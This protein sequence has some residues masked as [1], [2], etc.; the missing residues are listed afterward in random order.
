MPTDFPLW[1]LR[2]EDAARIIILEPLTK[3]TKLKFEHKRIPRVHLSPRSA[4]RQDDLQALNRATDVRK[5]EAH[6]EAYQKE[7]PVLGVL[8]GPMYRNGRFYQHEVVANPLLTDRPRGPWAGMY[9]R[10]QY[11]LDVAYYEAARALLRENFILGQRKEGPYLDGIIFK[12]ADSLLLAEQEHCKARLQAMY[13]I[14]D[15]SRKQKQIKS[16]KRDKKNTTGHWQNIGDN[17]AVAFK[18]KQSGYAIRKIDTLS[19][20]HWEVQMK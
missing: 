6:F 18:F 15:Q 2:P 17:E 8:I 13:A 10:E 7:Y 4:P 9:S 12:K 11:E 1:R 16:G 20:R 5:W 14:L 19:N 3:T